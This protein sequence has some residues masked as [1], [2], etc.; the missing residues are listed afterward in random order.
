MRATILFWTI[1]TLET[2]GACQG[3]HCVS[4][5]EVPAIKGDVQGVPLNLHCGLFNRFEFQTLRFRKI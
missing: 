5:D 3:T 1:A 2:Y 4:E